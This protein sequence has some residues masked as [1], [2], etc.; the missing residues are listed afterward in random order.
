MTEKTL[1]MNVKD[2]CLRVAL[3]VA[4]LVICTAIVPAQTI[5]TVAG[6]GAVAYSG[7]S[8]PATAAA[9]NHPR[10]VAIDAAGN[11]YVADLD[12]SR[13]RRIG[14]DG[15]INTVAGNGVAGFSGDGE[16][17]T[18]AMLNRPQAVALDTAGNL[19]IADTQNRR[20]RKVDALGVISTIAGTG[21]E[22]YSGDG[23]PAAL[24]MIQQAVDLAADGAGNV[25]FAD[26]SGHRIRKISSNGII[27]TVAGTGVAGPLGDGSPATAAQLN[28]PVG[29]AVDSKNNLYIADGDNFRIRV[30]LDANSNIYTVAG[31]GTGGF[32]GDG[33]P[34]LGAKL[35]FAL[36]VR[37][38]SSGR[39]FIADSANNRVRVVTGLDISTLAGTGTDG[40]SGDG[41]PAAS[42]ML[43]FP[44]A[45][46]LD[47]AGN[48]LLG[49]R[50]NSRVRKITLN[51]QGQPI[52]SANSMVN[53]ASFAPAGTAA[54]AVAPGSIVAIFGADLASGT[55]SAANVP[56]PIAIA[57]ATVT[58]NGIV[59]ALF[60]VSPGQINAQVPFEVAGGFG[61][62]SI[63]V[64]VKRASQST[65]VQ[66]AQ[67]A[68]V[69]PGIFT[70]NSR[71]TGDGAIL[72]AANFQL[73]TSGD[74]AR[75]GE[76]VSIY[77][78]GLGTTNPLVASG[79]ASPNA[80]PLARTLTTPLVTI[81]GRAAVVSFSGMAPGFVGLYQINVQIPAGLGV[82][83][84]QVAIRM[85]GVEGNITTIATQ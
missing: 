66:T 38:D 44:W 75:A 41:G 60:Y 83:S 80:E 37:V 17:A 52:L 79:A 53:G 10:G 84:Q 56:L 85:N 50:V 82:G 22:G 9:L 57:D 33:G 67:L 34:A 26:S 43:N 51:T 31:T 59:A 74:P 5:T 21:V 62:T 72:H 16:A 42:A 1:A 14:A 78:T 23:G 30:V 18:A 13:I 49:D 64:Q 20:I 71:G 27:T 8:G 32:S 28:F 70:V 39:I 68:A 45:L 55:A 54:G 19:I 69:S 2:F 63:S 47:N 24:A 7:D 4:A 46:A 3:P 58:M 65:A 11:I 73:V 48:L 36:G 6:N 29:V 77:C 76:F 15:M 81:G 35:N 40:Y 12:N 61:I 25:Y